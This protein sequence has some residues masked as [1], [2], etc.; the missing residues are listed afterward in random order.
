MGDAGWITTET[1]LGVMGGKQF[2][3]SGRTTLQT[4][5]HSLIL[6]FGNIKTKCFFPSDTQWNA[7]V[8]SKSQTSLDVNIKHQTWIANQS[9]MSPQFML[10]L[11]LL[12]SMSPF[13]YLSKLGTCVS[14]LGNYKIIIPFSAFCW[15]FYPG[16]TNT[17]LVFR[18]L[19]SWSV[20]C[21]EEHG[22]WNAD[23]IKQMNPTEKLIH[24]LNDN[25]KSGLYKM[26]FLPF[27]T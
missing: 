19:L 11:Q 24:H 5:T 17:K 8:L 10:K 21:R 13:T 23:V 6:L 7:S 20:T 15:V 22:W 12:V 4:C 14:I 25:S 27:T 26:S 3:K 9:F 18:T 2:S 16:C 1:L